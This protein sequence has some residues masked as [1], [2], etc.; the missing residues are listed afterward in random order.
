[1]H[2]EEKQTKSS[3]RPHVPAVEQACMLLLALVKERS[4]KKTLTELC[5]DTGI[6]KGRGYSLLNTL[7]K[8]NFVD[9]DPNSKRYNLGTSFLLLSSFASETTNIR[10]IVVSLLEKLATETSNSALF[11]LR[12]GDHLY[13]VAKYE[14]KENIGVSIALGRKLPLTRGAHGKAFVAFMPEAERERILASDAIFYNESI[15]LSNINEIRKELNKIREKGFAVDIGGVVSG[16]NALSAPVFG[17]QEKIIGC[18]E[19]FGLS[20]SFSKGSLDQYGKKVAQ[21]AEQVSQRLKDVLPHHNLD[22]T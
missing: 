7:S 14:G 4:S 3:F 8:F 13:F 20:S 22:V 1:M 21:T 17:P 2:L 12:S 16:V 9:R 19:L 11:G 18:I 10:S 15:K 6:H 5:R